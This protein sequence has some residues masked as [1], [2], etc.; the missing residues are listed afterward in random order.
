M[1]YA[2]L[3]PAPEQPPIVVGVP[4][5]LPT[6]TPSAPPAPQPD[7]VTQFAQCCRCQRLRWKEDMRV[8]PDTQEYICPEGQCDPPPGTTSPRPR[9]R[10]CCTI[11]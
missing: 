4:L 9:S 1:S 6:C 8:L 7:L 11:C 3:P 5:D 2:R 10:R